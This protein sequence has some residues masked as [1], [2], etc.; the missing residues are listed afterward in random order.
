MSQN[1][2]PR[3]TTMA[4]GAMLL[5]CVCGSGLTRGKHARRNEV[6]CERSTLILA[7]LEDDITDAKARLG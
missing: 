2:G 3:V 4:D 6:T 7:F 5:M 1:H